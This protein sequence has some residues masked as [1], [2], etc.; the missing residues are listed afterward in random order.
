MKLIR[1]VLAL[2][3]M[4][5]PALALEYPCPSDPGFCYR[6]VGNDGC[7]DGGVDDGPIKAEIEGQF[8]FP[9]FPD[10]GSIVCPPVDIV[11][12]DI[13]GRKGTP[14]ITVSAGSGST[15]DLTG[16]TVK[17]ATLVTNCETVVGP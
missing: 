2:L 11:E 13:R 16:T 17:K 7:F 5:P 14:T 3:L 15:C 9:P 6:D 1:A 12:S 10:P 8:S 4:A